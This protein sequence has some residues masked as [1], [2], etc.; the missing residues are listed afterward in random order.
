MLKGLAAVFLAALALAAVILGIFYLIGILAWLVTFFAFGIIVVAIIFFIIIFIFGAI[1]FFAMFY[2]M[3]E[4]KPTIQN[5]G[6]YSIKDE[7]GK[8][9]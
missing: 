2:Y 5:D 9:E 4:K 6:N 1:T 8:N 3:A 7:K